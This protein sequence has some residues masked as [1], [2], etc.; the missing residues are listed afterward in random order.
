MDTRVEVPLDV[1]RTLVARARFAPSP[2]NTQP[3]RWSVRGDDARDAV[4]EVELTRVGDRW[5]SAGDPAG[6]ELAISCGAALLTLRV[7]AA[8][9]L[10]DTEV[11]VLPEPQRPDLLARVRFVV[12]AVDAAFSGLDAAIPVRHTWRRGFA[13]RAVP[14]GLASRLAAQTIGYGV[15][16]QTLTA[17]E[18]PG[19]AAL[20]RD[21]DTEYYRDP[22][23][24]AEAARWLQLRRRGEGVP[25]PV[26]CLLP[27]R[28]ALRH[29]DIGRRLG[30]QRAGLLMAAPLALVLRTPED[31]I[32][33]WLAAGQALQHMLLLTA[34]E[35][36]AVGFV[37]RPC[38]DPQRREALRGMLDGD[39]HPQL[40]L[41]VGYPDSGWRMV[42]RLPLDE[43]LGTEWAPAV[44]DGAED[45][46]GPDSGQDDLG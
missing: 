34:A 14:E 5:L 22:A 24:R 13:R 7:A 42:P 33:S 29:T 32:A 3:W 43:V 36:L 2:R 40:V 21:C 41:R 23:R 28:M 37:N 35:G 1:V 12:G 38:Q 16:L 4:T 31:D 8:E 9:A 19:V 26:A 45:V 46:T 6:R 30:A 10:L 11:D 27:A 20:V 25:T 39:G 44:R 15:Y 18:R 17:Q